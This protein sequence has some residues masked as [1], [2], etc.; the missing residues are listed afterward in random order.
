MKHYYRNRRHP[1]DNCAGKYLKPYQGLKLG[2]SRLTSYRG[3]AGKYLK[4]YQGLKPLMK[5]L[6]DAVSRRKIPKTLSG[7]ETKLFFVADDGTPPENT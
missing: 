1:L 2:G 7:I 5:V 6:P 4:P 3:N